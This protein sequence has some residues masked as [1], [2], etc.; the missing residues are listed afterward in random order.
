ME[1]LNPPVTTT[2]SKTT[3]WNA[4]K[5]VADEYD[6]EFLQNWGTDLDAALIFVCGT[7]C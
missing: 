2:D 3:F 1:A 6:K 5:T 7:N 4:Y